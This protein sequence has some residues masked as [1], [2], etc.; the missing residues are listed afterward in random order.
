MKVWIDGMRIWIRGLG[1]RRSRQLGRRG[2]V[3]SLWVVSIDGVVGKSRLFTGR[4][5]SKD[6]AGVVVIEASDR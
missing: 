5:I 4:F 2:P 6:I 3:L 1:E